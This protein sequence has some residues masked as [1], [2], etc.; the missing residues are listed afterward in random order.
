M[1]YKYILFDLDGTL[2]DSQ[3]GITKCVQYALRSFGIEEK[4]ENLTCFIGPPL[5]DMFSSK[6]GI[7]GEA[8]TQKYRERFSTVGLF[9]NRVYDGIPSLLGELKNNGAT[10]A[11]ATSKPEVYSRRILDK[12]DLSRYFDVIVGCNLDGSREKKSEVIAEALNQLGCPEKSSVIM[13]GDRHHDVEGASENGIS[14]VG[15]DYGFS[16]PGELE[17]A[18]AISVVKS[19]DELRKAL[20]GD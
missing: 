4:C 19:V 20:I 3:E 16:G 15:V 1:K 9:E 12:F 2:T 7:D 10:L 17:S 13:V 18:G 8:A 6:Y 5:R 14:T 11:V